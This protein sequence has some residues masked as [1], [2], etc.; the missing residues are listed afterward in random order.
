MRD[1]ANCSA[2]CTNKKIKKRVAS[3][4]VLAS[5]PVSPSTKGANWCCS[6]GVFSSA[7]SFPLSVSDPSGS[8]HWEKGPE[9]LVW[10]RACRQPA[11][12]LANHAPLLQSPFRTFSYAL[13]CIPHQSVDS[14]EYQVTRAPQPAFLF[15]GQMHCCNS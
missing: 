2:C 12:L 5:V 4:S 9:P 7:V 11:S 10:R 3:G 15:L 1:H 6:P 8:L 13:L 14:M